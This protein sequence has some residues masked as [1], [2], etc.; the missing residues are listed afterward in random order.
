[1][2]D[3]SEFNIDKELKELVEKLPGAKHYFENRENQI[4]YTNEAFLPVIL[5]FEEKLNKGGKGIGVKLT[6]VSEIKPPSS[7]VIESFNK[8]KEMFGPPIVEVIATI[9]SISKG[10]DFTLQDWNACMA[11]FY[12]A[13]LDP[14]EQVT[15]TA[16]QGSYKTFVDLIFFYVGKR[17][18]RPLTITDVPT[19]AN[20]PEKV[21][22]SSEPSGMP[23]TEKISRLKEKSFVKWSIAHSPNLLMAFLGLLLFSMELWSFGGGNFQGDYVFFIMI[24]IILISLAF[25]GK[26]YDGQE[27]N[28]NEKLQKIKNKII[29]ESIEAEEE[30]KEVISSRRM[31]MAKSASKKYKCTNPLCRGYNQYVPTQ[32]TYTGVV[33]CRYCNNKIKED[34]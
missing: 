29:G 4:K 8:R 17:D 23:I 15:P 28:T 22:T 2:A 18:S 32:K 11:I 7:D 3:S 14:I 10:E 34:A 1:M 13:G 24:G 33:L 25:M 26:W 21:I 31:S 12:D 6:K 9:P 19:Y 16:I 27:G 20:V 5:A 30:P